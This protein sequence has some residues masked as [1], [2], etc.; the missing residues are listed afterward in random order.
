M[1]GHNDIHYFDYAATTFMCESSIKEYIDFQRNVSVL[2]GKGGNNLSALSKKLFDEAAASIRK[3][4]RLDTDYKLI[5]GKNT[6]EVINIIAMSI[7]HLL[8]PMDIILIGPYEH[9]SNFLT[10]KYLARRTNAIFI[11]MPLL[12]DGMIDIE[13]L[14]TIAN[15]VKVVA[16]SSVANTNGFI[17]NKKSINALF[18]CDTLIFSDESQGVAH[19][20][21]D[22]DCKR[23]RLTAPQ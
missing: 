18:G 12:K 15:N 6:T 11:E 1:L 5:I 9:H 4:F 14:K 3:H 19:S 2:W 8:Q 17:V 23:P 7:E 21:I 22:I 16:Y 10:W 20:S 13:Y